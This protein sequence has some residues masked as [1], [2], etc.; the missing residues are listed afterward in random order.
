MKRTLGN[1][2]QDFSGGGVEVRLFMSVCVGD[3]GGAG[4]PAH[5]VVLALHVVLVVLRRAASRYDRPI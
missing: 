2:G 1:F 5:H 4:G 3:L